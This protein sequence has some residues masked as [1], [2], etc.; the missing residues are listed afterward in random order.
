MRTQV[1]R[2]KVTNTP[3]FQLVWRVPSVRRYQRIRKT[4]DVW[5]SVM[6]LAD[7]PCEACLVPEQLCRIE[8]IGKFHIDRCLQSRI[9]E[10][11][12]RLLEFDKVS[13]LFANKYAIKR[14][15]ALGNKS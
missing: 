11:P 3:V 7:R 1:L 15:H 6:P 9:W 5:P 4:F 14:C 2:Q 10:A 13:L 12:R 8:I